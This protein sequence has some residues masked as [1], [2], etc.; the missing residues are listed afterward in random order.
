MVG[1][2]VSGSFR[3]FGDSRHEDFRCAS[4]GSFATNP[5][6]IYLDRSTVA[7]M[8]ARWTRDREV[9]GLNPAGSYETASKIKPYCSLYHVTIN[10]HGRVGPIH[11]GM[12]LPGPIAD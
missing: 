6:K 9:P 3:S 12:Y 11:L 1:D 10:S 8:A 5:K 7:Q 4:S 2:E